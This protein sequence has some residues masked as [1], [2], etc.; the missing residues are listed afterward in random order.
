MG[1]LLV[2]GFG[3]ALGLVLLLFATACH[4]TGGGP[5]VPPLSPVPPTTPPRCGG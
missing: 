4:S 5:A 2:H 1:R 3:L